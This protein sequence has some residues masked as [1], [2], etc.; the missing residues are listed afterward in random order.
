MEDIKKIR[1][2]ESI[3]HQILA[4][5]LKPVKYHLGLLFFRVAVATQ[6]LVVHGL[7]K[8]QPIHGAP[9]VPNPFGWPADVNHCIALAGSLYFPIFIILGLLTRLAALPA[10]AVTATGYFIVHAGEPAALRD[11]PFMYSICL[12]LIALLGAGRY[13]IDYLLFKESE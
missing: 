9:E 1:L 2:M 4:P 13:S 7:K 11:I 3:L 12:L 5:Q 6:L 8:L 10:L